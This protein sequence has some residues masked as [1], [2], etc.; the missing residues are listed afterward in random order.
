MNKDLKDIENQLS[1][2]IVK[3][4]YNPER[5]PS[6]IPNTE[7]GVRFLREQLVSAIIK[8]VEPL[9]APPELQVTCEVQGNRII[10]T[11]EEINM[12]LSYRQRGKDR[13]V[14]QMPF[15]LH[16]DRRKYTGDRRA[17]RR[18]ERIERPEFSQIDLEEAL[19]KTNQPQEKKRAKR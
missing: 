12:I 18:G 16:A 15:L 9:L 5:M 7:T 4:L 17:E 3:I 6:K 10:I 11:A 1:A 2:A 14:I 19:A 8:I 13:R